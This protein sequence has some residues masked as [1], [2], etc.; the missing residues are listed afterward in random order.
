MNPFEVFYGRK[1]N[2]P[3]SWDNRVDKVVIG[4]DLLKEME[5]NMV[6]IKKNLKAYQERQNIFVN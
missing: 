1:C 6:K 5:E 3:V 4:L 2:M